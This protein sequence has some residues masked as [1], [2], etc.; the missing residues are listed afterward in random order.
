MQYGRPATLYPVGGNQRSNTKLV[1][2]EGEW[3]IELI[4][5]NAVSEEQAAYTIANTLHFQSLPP[6][7]GLMIVDMAVPASSR[8]VSLAAAVTTLDWVQGSTVSWVSAS[9]A[10]S[11]DTTHG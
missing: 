1:F 5:S 4:G 8:A 11:I 3:T 10:S 6:Y 9:Q 7:P 2:T